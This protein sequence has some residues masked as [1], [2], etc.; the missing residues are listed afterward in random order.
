M[1]TVKVGNSDIFYEWLGERRHC[2]PV[3]VPVNTLISDSRILREL[4][5]PNADIP[6]ILLIDNTNRGRSTYTN[7]PI[8]LARQVEEIHAVIAAEQVSAPVWMGLSSVNSLAYR[9]A[10][11]IPSSGL[12]F[13]S[14]IFT[15]GLH[16]RVSIARDL[17][18]QSLSDTS[19]RQFMQLMSLMAH[20]SHYLETDRFGAMSRLKVLRECYTPE[21]FAIVLR[22]SFFPEPDDE[23]IFRSVS[24]PVLAVCGAE[25]AIE[26]LRLLHQVLSYLPKPRLVTLDCGHQVMI[27]AKEELMAH[28]RLFMKGL[29]VRQLA[30]A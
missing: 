24:C 23:R 21:Q 13:V 9:A 16:R 11:A 15:F 8:S 22:Q 27:E 7:E 1:A 28:L 5:Q 2:G 20:G 30:H 12:V 17:L 6:A 3:L 18:L 10:A 19:F 25:E 14:P 29:G 26:P 4:L